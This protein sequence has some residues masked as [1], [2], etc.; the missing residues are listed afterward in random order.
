MFRRCLGALAGLGLFLGLSSNAWAGNV[1]PL[2][3]EA[4]LQ[5]S[6]NSSLAGTVKCQLATAT[7]TY[8]ASHQF[9]SDLSGL[10]SSAQTL[11]SKTYTTGKFTA[12]NIT[13]TAV[14]VGSTATQVLCWVDTGT[15]GTSRLIVDLTGIS[16]VTNG[17]DVVIS[18]D[19]SLGL[20]TL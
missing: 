17:G 14:T 20:F 6:A 2:W 8:S 15:A 11:A 4:I 9:L 1:Y 18:W 16:V 10:I 7:Y 13:F 5:A 3:K 12:A 19:G